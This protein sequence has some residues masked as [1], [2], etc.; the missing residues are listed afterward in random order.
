MQYVTKGFEAFRKGSFDNGGQN[1]YVSR[2]GILQRIFQYD[3][4]GDGYPDLIFSNSQSMNERP[5][6]AVYSHL[7]ENDFCDLLPSNGTFDGIL[8]DLFHSGYSDLV[9]ACQH[10]GTHSDVCAVIYFGSAEGFSESLRMELPAPNAVS[11]CAGDFFGTGNP[12]LAFASDGKLRVFQQVQTGGFLA[13]QY[14]DYPICVSRMVSADLDGDGYGDIVFKTPDGRAGILFGGDKGFRLEEILWIDGQETARGNAASGSTEGMVDSSS[15]W[16]PRILDID[17]QTYLFIVHDA[18]AVFYRCDSSRQLSVAFALD[19]PG[20]VDVAAADLTGTGKTDL[21]LAVFNGRDEAGPCRIYL[22]GETGIDENRYIVTPVTGASCVTVAN[23][24]GNVLVFGRIGQAKEQ[25]VESPVLRVSPDGVVTE[26]A[27]I[28]CGD[29]MTV[30]AGAPNPVTGC[31]RIVVMNHKGNRLVGEEDV[32]VYLGGPDGYQADRKLCLPGYSTVDSAMCDFFDRGLVDV[33]L[34]CCYEDAPQKNRG[35]RIHVNN[36]SGFSPDQILE[37]PTLHTHGMAV[38]DFRKSGYLDIATGGI[39]NREIKIFHGSAEGYSEDNCT[40]IVLGPDDGTYVPRGHRGEN[41]FIRDFSPEDKKLATE[42]GQV[43]WLLAADFN[44]DGWLDLFVSEVLGKKSFI[45]WGGPDGFSYENRQEI[46]TDGVG[47]ATA[48]DLNGNGWLDLI[49]AQHQSIGKKNPKESYVTVYWGGPEGYQE[50]RKMQLPAH[51]AN[52]AT[53]GDFN[54]NGSLDIYATSYNNGRCR[55]LLSFLYKG[56][57]GTYSQRNVQ[58]LFNHSGCGCVAG[59]FNGDGYTDLAVACHK[60][61]G[62]HASHSFIFW[63]GPEGLSEDRKTVLPTLGPH[64][65][66]TIDPG[67]IRDRGDR[68]YYTSAEFVLQPDK[69]VS[70]VRWEGECTST[71]WVEV[72]LRCAPNKE[73]LKTAPWQSVTP[74]TDL[75]AFAFAGVVQYRLALCARCACGTPRISQVTVFIKPMD[76]AI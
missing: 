8:V 53:V 19:C 71:S 74:D 52:S 16:R 35:A 62:N 28:L 73:T 49:L 15:Q 4:N 43:R 33:L 47:S 64:G 13:A 30:L 67:N 34:A 38:G 55:D 26:I 45:L 36:G 10:D 60:E 41:G 29:A 72:E 27:R 63:G 25:E 54:G 5:P 32:Y 3:I 1:L 12:A 66:S 59:D 50:N 14:T 6:I 18:E 61:Y 31:D 68:E 23:L 51:C 40:R 39:F 46:L 65:M 70:S 7:P 24:Q 2:K 58:Y 22:S 21:A 11:V 56:E 69:V 17:G 75:T 48:A 20:V 42:Y 37:L 57:N 44:G 9:V 76:S